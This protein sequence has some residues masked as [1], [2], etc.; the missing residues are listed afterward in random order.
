MASVEAVEHL[1]INETKTYLSN[2]HHVRDRAIVT[3]ILST[4]LFLK[5]VIELEMDDIDW[6]K[7]CITISK[8]RARQ[9]GL[10]GEAFEALSNWSQSRPD[11]PI[12]NV[13]ITTK[14]ATKELSERSID[15]IIRKYSNTDHLSRKVNSNILRNTFA[16]RFLGNATDIKAASDILGIKDAD[17]IKRY[18]ETAKQARTGHADDGLDATDSR[19]ILT[20]LIQDNFPTKPRTPR[21]Q[22]NVSGPIDVT[23]EESI[24]GRSTLIKTLSSYLSRETDI[25]I[26]GNLGLGKTHLLK[27]IHHQL[28]DTSVY[29]S[30]PTPFKQCLLAICN[31]LSPDWPE[32]LGKRANAQAL[33]EHI[34][35]LQVPSTFV[36]IIDNLH[37]LRVTDTEGFLILIKQFTILAGTENTAPKL[38]TIW[39]KFKELP[40]E[41]LSENACRDL[42]N[43]LTQNMTIEDYEMMEHSV[44]NEANGYPLAIVDMVTHLRMEHVVKR[45]DLRQMSHSAGTQYRDWSASIMVLWGLVIAA[46]FIAL[47]VHSFEGYILAGIGVAFMAIMRFMVMKAR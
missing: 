21:K 8:N 9:L 35:T 12:K 41:P 31:H 44:L 23:P 5:E 32:K 14:G 18:L 46:R 1:S 34:E 40:L 6:E 30:S 22:E 17:S 36:L 43:Y 27:H 33:L 45:S 39:W 7:R 24:F 13:F 19:P 10:N 26:V 47:G 29:V 37:K 42:L 38:K 16:V 15:H 28:S 4:G 11:T 2:I 3:L 20:K 25:L